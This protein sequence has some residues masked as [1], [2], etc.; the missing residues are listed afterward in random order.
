MGLLSAYTPLWRHFSH[1]AIE[2]AASQYFHPSDCKYVNSRGWRADG[3]MQPD[4]RAL[5]GYPKRQAVIYTTAEVRDILEQYTMGF[6][7]EDIAAWHE[8]S[9]GGIASLIRSCQQAVT[10][11]SVTVRSKRKH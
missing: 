1:A 5:W 3:E 11:H 8:R 7:I 9:V 4:Y 10:Q 6:S 2:I